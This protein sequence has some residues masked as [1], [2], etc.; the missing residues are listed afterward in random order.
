METVGQVCK[1]KD[2]DLFKT[3]DGNR[4]IEKGRVNKI[5]KS[6]TENGYIHSPII[7]NENMEVIDGQGRLEA[8]KSFGL[9]VEYVVFN[10]LTIKD[11]IA[12]NVYQTGWTI[13]DYIESHADRGSRSYSFLLHLITK[14]RN[15]G[16]T[17]VIDAI[18]GSVG[19]NGRITAKIKA[20]EFECSGEQYERADELLGYVMKFLKTIKNFNKG[21]IPYICMALM[22]AYQLEDVDKDKLVDKFDKY[23]GMDDIPSFTSTDGALKV[24]TLI[25]NR[26]NSKSKIYFEVEYDK[27]M[28]GK[29]QWYS[30]KW[31]F[32]KC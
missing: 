6:I 25:Y 20:G 27:Y 28:S 3:L 8:L 32:K 23:Y 2:Y 15:L 1:T 7:V 26:R 12:L 31:G 17:V 22:F 10:G 19:N 29:Y 24:L 21:P 18:T 13:M 14:Y 4:S 30:N 11:C 16:I 9:P 5:K